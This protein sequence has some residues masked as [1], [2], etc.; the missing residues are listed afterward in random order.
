MDDTFSN[1]AYHLM[2]G[3]IH[4]S[5]NMSVTNKVI[6]SLLRSSKPLRQAFSPEHGWHG[7]L[8]I[9]SPCVNPGL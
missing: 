8:P 4:L 7:A 6:P 9:I 3:A 1:M 5:F 2:R